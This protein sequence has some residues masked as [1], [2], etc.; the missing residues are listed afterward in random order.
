MQLLSMKRLF[1]QYDLVGEADRKGDKDP[2]K[3]AA[4]IIAQLDTAG[5]KKITRAEFIAG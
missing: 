1:F 2:K 5:D 4:D 3:R